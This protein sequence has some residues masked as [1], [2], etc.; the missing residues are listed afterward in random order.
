MSAYRALSILAAAFVTRFAFQRR[1]GDPLD[2]GWELLFSR[3]AYLRISRKTGGAS[4]LL[5]P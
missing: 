3:S 1:P 5:V 4:L 2:T